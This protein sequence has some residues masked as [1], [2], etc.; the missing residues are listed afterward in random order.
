MQELVDL[1][2]PDIFHPALATNPKFFYNHLRSRFRKAL[3]SRQ[4]S[5]GPMCEVTGKLF[6][7]KVFISP[8][9]AESIANNIALATNG[10]WTWELQIRSHF[11]GWIVIRVDG[12]IDGSDGGG[13]YMGEPSSISAKKAVARLLVART[14]RYGL[15]EEL[16]M[17]QGAKAD[18]H[19]KW[20]IAQ[21]E[22]AMESLSKEE[23]DRSLNATYAE[24][25]GELESIEAYEKKGEALL[26][27]VWKDE[28]WMVLQGVELDDGNEE[29]VNVEVV[30]AGPSSY[31]N[32]Y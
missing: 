1:Y 6:T 3:V 13:G 18:V 16:E 19:K 9:Q 22:I 17:L 24:L 7:D 2:T 25:I 29:D 27:I 32:A 31:G 23:R 4:H 28:E 5:R 26:R 30:K 8:S 12:Q 15:E 10:F 21:D 11:A 14:A 20:E